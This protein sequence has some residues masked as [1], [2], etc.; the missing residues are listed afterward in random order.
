MERSVSDID[1]LIREEKRLTALESQSEAWAEGV[2]AG[3]EPEILAEAALSTAFAEL[4]RSGGEQA[5]LSLLDRMRERV[6]AGE[7][8]PGLVRH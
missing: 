4:L 5:A 6:I 8:E 2:S 3:I 7:F 1:A